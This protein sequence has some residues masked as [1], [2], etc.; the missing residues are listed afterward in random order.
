MATSLSANR[1]NRVKLETCIDLV[2]QSSAIMDATGPAAFC[3]LLIDPASCTWDKC[4]V[5]HLSGRPEREWCSY[6]NAKA[7]H[8]NYSAASAKVRHFSPAS[9]WPVLSVLHDQVPWLLSMKSNNSS[10]IHN[11]SELLTPMS[12]PIALSAPSHSRSHHAPRSRP[13]SSANVAQRY[14][15]F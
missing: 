4:C 6:R 15:E 10:V 2:G 11:C 5:R 12:A 13:R 7:W 8:T 1:C 3:S 14:M 9:A